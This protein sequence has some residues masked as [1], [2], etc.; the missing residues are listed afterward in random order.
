VARRILIAI[1]CAAVLSGVPSAGGEAV[2]LGA[3]SIGV[4]RI[5][6]SQPIPK[7]LS[8]VRYLLLDASRARRVGGLKR[9]YPRL[10]VLAYKNLSFLIDYSRRLDGNA[11]VPWA[12]A[13]KSWFLRDRAGRRV[14]SAHFKHAWF[15][16]VGNAA[17]QRAWAR[18][19]LRFLRRAPWDGVFMDDALADP[20]WHLGGRYQRL[21]RYPNRDAYRAA[22]RSLLAALQPALTRAG[23]VQIANI[24]ASTDQADVWTDWAPL[25]SGEL[26][27][28]FLK[29]GKGTEPVVTGADWAAA[30]GIEQA[31]EATGRAFLA[32][33]YGP[34]SDTAAQ[35]YTRAS[36]LLFN[37]PE[38]GSA[39]IWGPH[40]TQTS[41]LDLGL[42]LGAASQNGA[43]WT[44][45]FTG[46]LLTVDPSAGTYSVTG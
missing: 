45:P 2:A 13:R 16:D 4:L 36:F 25:L 34:S 33:S 9:S 40:A 12:K 44:R 10:R 38:T 15:A 37:R 31:V 5:I 39:S 11:G 3:P 24:G 32:L 46:G 18:N 30:I 19:V 41:T 28:H 23:Y 17:Y 7:D 26:D 43:T 29:P 27:E 6:P 35:G 1:L 22:E 21:A 42:P 20:G 14:H 8:G